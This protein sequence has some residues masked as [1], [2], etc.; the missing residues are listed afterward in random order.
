MT[1]Q[2]MYCHTNGVLNLWGIDECT[3][4]YCGKW[5]DLDCCL[6]FESLL[7]LHSFVGCADFCSTHNIYKQLIARLLSELWILAQA[8]ESNGEK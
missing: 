1:V 7:L 5:H 3:P 8:N 4:M 2:T 6:G